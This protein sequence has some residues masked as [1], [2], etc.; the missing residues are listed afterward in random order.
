MGPKK[1]KPATRETADHSLPYCVAVALADGAV[2]SRSFSAER[3]SDPKLYELMQKIRVYSNADLTAQYPKV[4]PNEI[5]IQ[6]GSGKVIERR[7]SY[8][9]GHP[10]NPLT[11]AEVETKFRG[12][13]SAFFPERA[14]SKILAQVW[15][16]EKV[17]SLEPVLR[18]L[19]LDADKT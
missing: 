4:M 14:M 12:L 13:A 2:T 5:R 8:A 10:N 11:D 1:W 6:L 9:H 18:M 19:N 17:Q 16:L 15:D 7:V 3:I